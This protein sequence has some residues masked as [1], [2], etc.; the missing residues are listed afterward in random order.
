MC[1]SVIH[2]FILHNILYICITSGMCRERDRADNLK[3]TELAADQ[4]LLR[5]WTP[6]QLIAE[7]LRTICV[8]EHEAWISP[9]L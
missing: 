3:G 2:I 1:Y 9:S 5:L 6:S 7:Q 4:Y 8:S